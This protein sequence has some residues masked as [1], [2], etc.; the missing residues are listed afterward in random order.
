[1]K[2]Q[3][4]ITLIALVITIIVLL[5]LAGVSIAML[6]GEGGILNKATT[7]TDKTLVGEVDEAVKLA[8]SE[9]VANQLDPTYKAPTTEGAL[10]ES[11]VTVDVVTKLM[12]AN[13]SNIG[14]KIAVTVAKKDASQEGEA[15]VVVTYTVTKTNEAFTWEIDSKG[16]L[17]R[18]D[19]I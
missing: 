2:K 4:G 10:D 5:I 16:A 7:A 8:V 1:M 15:P 17:T 14:T 13:N 9:I 11:Q 3:N 12:R 18:S 6:A 19:N